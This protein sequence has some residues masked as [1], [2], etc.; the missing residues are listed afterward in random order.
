[1]RGVGQGDP[2]SPKPF[3]AALEE[4]FKNIDWSDKGILVDGEHLIH[5]RF[6]DDV[7]KSVTSQRSSR[8]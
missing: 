1:M 7:L 6:A 8:E 2:V 4:V 5:L 3:T